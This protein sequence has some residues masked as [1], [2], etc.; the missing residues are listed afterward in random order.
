LDL[1]SPYTK[2]GIC[3]ELSSNFNSSD[4]IPALDIISE[5]SVAHFV[6]VG[7]FFAET[8]GILISCCSCDVS[9]SISESTLDPI[10]VNSG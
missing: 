1:T 7:C 3:S 10:I 4:L 8:L 5:T 6:T 9:I 2:G